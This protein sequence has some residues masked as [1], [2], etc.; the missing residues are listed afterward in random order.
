[1][2]DIFGFAVLLGFFRQHGLALLREPWL[3]VQ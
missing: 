2:S 1:M 3:L